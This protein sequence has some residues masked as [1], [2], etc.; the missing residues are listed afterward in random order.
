ME[1]TETNLEITE[2]AIIDKQKLYKILTYSLLGLVFLLF[3]SYQVLTKLNE[4]PTNFPTSSP[5]TIPE[6][7]SAKQATL[8]LENE[9]YIRS[10][11]LLNLIL[12]LW[13][14]PNSIKASTYI[15][16][17]PLTSF[18]IA[19]EITRGRFSDDLIKFTH[20]EG[21]SVATL[22]RRADLVLPEFEQAEFLALAK[23]EEGYLF[24]ETYLI[25]AEYT[26]LDLFN[27]LRNTFDEKIANLESEIA[28][29][30]RSLPE[31]VIL[32]SII[33][34]EANTYESKRMVSGILQNRLDIGMALQADA[35]IEYVLDKPLK[36]L[37]SEDL[38]IDS[39]YNTYLNR[40]LPPTPIGNPG[41]EAIMAVLEPAET[42]YLFYITGNDGQFYYAENFDQH[43]LNIAR[44]LR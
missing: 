25:P 27:L 34:R 26:A 6:G 14:D 20:I 37:T 10:N 44:H 29:Q 39:P 38:K 5:V 33:E 8:I 41:L 17:E 15:F 43:R 30:E 24:P 2:V 32:A 23:S 4:P 1:P 36:E 18:N 11:G 3:I 31:I 7:T 28:N 12:I 22:A 13:Y 42:D 16:N 21:E 35:S 19:E 9:G 40:G